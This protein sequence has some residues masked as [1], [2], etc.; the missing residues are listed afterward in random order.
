MMSAQVWIPLLFLVIGFF[1]AAVAWREYHRKDTT[2]SP[3]FKAKSRVAGIF[4][5]VSLILFFFLIL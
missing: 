2:D 5:I 1:H 3:V 4:I